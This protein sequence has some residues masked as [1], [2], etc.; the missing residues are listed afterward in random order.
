MN[1]DISL[2]LAL[3]RITSKLTKMP[4]T[5]QFSIISMAPGSVSFLRMIP[6]RAVQVSEDH[7]GISEISI[8]YR[9]TFRRADISDPNNW[10]AH[11][12][13]DVGDILLEADGMQQFKFGVQVEDPNALTLF[14]SKLRLRSRTY[15]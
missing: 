13:K 3:N 6:S 11:I 9:L 8:D 7:D 4:H 10:A 12:M 2:E 1:R 15:M 5:T 14:L